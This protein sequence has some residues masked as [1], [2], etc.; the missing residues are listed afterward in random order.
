MI[1]TKI[2]LLD[3]IVHNSEK[4]DGGTRI[5]LALTS[6]ACITPEATQKMELRMVWSGNHGLVFKSH[7]KLQSLLSDTTSSNVI[8][9]V[10]VKPLEDIVSVV[11]VDYPYYSF[12]V[13]VIHKCGFM[14]N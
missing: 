11:T 8:F 3:F 7:S 2:T 9:L 6:M 13:N 5:A 1:G 4:E 10:A 12:N 14:M